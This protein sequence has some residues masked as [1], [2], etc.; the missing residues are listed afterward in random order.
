MKKKILLI[1][2][3]FMILM[4]IPILA[5]TITNNFTIKKVDQDGNPIENVEFQVLMKPEIT[6][7]D[8]HVIPIQVI[9]GRYGRLENSTSYGFISDSEFWASIFTDVKHVLKISKDDE[10]ILTHEFEAG[11]DEVWYAPL[12]EGTYTLE[13]ENPNNDD[14]NLENLIWYEC[15]SSCSEDGAAY[16][17][18]TQ[19]LTVNADGTYSIDTTLYEN[20]T[21]GPNDVF[22]G[23]YLFGS[24]EIDDET[25][26]A[27]YEGGIDDYP[28]P[29]R[30]SNAEAIVVSDKIYLYNFILLFNNY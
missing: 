27:I 25:G 17:P 18:Y 11:S 19:T 28:F 24:V 30:H 15:D 8:T 6:Y 16:F 3:I 2:S 20:E 10:V 21:Y 26:E 13:Y 29:S 4:V 23:Y 14:L 9:Y 1:V 12:G 7:E 22:A 5:E